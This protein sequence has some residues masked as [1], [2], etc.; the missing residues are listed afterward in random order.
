MIINMI[1]KNK[2]LF[3]FFFFLLLSFIFNLFCLNS[4]SVLTEHEGYDSCVF[5]QM[6]LALVQGK[7]LY[8][9]LF[10]HKGPIIFYINAFAIY[11]NIGRWGLFLLHVL[12]YTAVFFLWHKICL[13]FGCKHKSSFLVVV[14]G[15]LLYLTL[16]GIEGN[17][18]EDWMMFPLSYG[19]YVGLK[20]SVGKNTN[21]FDYLMIGVFSGFIIFMRANSGVILFCTFV[22]LIHQAYTHRDF[23]KIKR[24]ICYV[25]LG[26][27]LVT[28]CILMHF[29]IMWG[30]QGIDNLIFGTFLFNFSVFNNVA[31]INGW[32]TYLLHLCFF[33]L[34]SVLCLYKKTLSPIVFIYLVS[35][36]SITYLLV[37][38]ARFDYYLMI[39][40][41][42]YIPVLGS[43]LSGKKY[44][45]LLIFFLLLLAKHKIIEGNVI[46][47]LAERE[48][49][50]KEF[51][52]IDRIMAQIP[53]EDLA[54]V[55]NYNAN[56]DGLQILQRKRITQCNMVLWNHQLQYSD[57]LQNAI[58]GQLQN[59]PPRW[60]IVEKEKPYIS[61]TDSVFIHNHYQ[62]VDSAYFT[63]RAASN[64]K[65]VFY[66][67][68]KYL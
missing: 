45:I 60:I 16:S 33:V 53:Q 24:I 66:F 51:Q 49:Y 61:R 34:L 59:N 2:N 65:I 14:F 30:W 35:C 55:W 28:L 8:K 68:K 4:I 22:L 10:D 63:N 48:R 27:L 19:V 44:Y 47:V 7:E 50:H 38:R 37:G 52:L 62:I 36:I 43:I 18:I 67:F 31:G 32:Y 57:R 54:S 11:L 64:K 42:L 40:I 26:F 13:L 12:N 15:L 5:K 58:K 6:G 17:R 29:Y 41:P 56:V 25:I 20:E 21:I 9:D 1:A 39:I 3:L 46:N 23:D